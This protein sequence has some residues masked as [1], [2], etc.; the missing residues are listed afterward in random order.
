[1]D[2]LAKSHE[3]WV[4]EALTRSDMVR[5]SK[6]TESIAVGSERYVRSIAAQL[7]DRQRVSTEPTPQEAS[8]G[9][10]WVRESRWPYFFAPKRAI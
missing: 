8:S 9:T 3:A 4:E 2:V 5:E 6:W 1:M 7:R 10:W